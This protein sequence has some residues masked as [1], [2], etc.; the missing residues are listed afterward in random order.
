MDG[1]TQGRLNDSIILGIF[2]LPYIYD[3]VIGIFS[4][5]FMSKIA[6]FNELMRAVDENPDREDQER[7]LGDVFLS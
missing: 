1:E 5:A 6:T 2:S 7:M 3:F 4:I